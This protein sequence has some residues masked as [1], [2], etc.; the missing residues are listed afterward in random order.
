MP[1]FGGAYAWI[2]RDGKEHFGVGGNIAGFGGWCGD[3]PI[4]NTLEQAF[5]VWQSTFEAA[6]VRSELAHRFEW[7]SFHEE[8]LRLAH[9]LK[10]ELG[11]EVRV[12]YEKPYED[13]WKDDDERR[14]ILPGG[15][16]RH[17]AGRGSL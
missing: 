12:I 13:P 11:N 15:M 17:L 16:V 3:F 8:G 1:D 9:A 10:A 7:D 5:E 14:E 2:C 4:S 6:G